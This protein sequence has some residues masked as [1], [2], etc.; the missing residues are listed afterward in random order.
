MLICSGN[1]RFLCTRKA[2]HLLELR[3]ILRSQQ[4][5]LRHVFF[6]KTLPTT[7][8]PSTS[9]LTACVRRITVHATYKLVQSAAKTCRADTDGRGSSLDKRL[10][11]LGCSNSDSDEADDGEKAQQSAHEGYESHLRARGCRPE[12]VG[13]RLQ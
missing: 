2:L 8:P 12:A 6:S 10:T 3:F 4:R 9:M 1:Y 7:M 5:V 13:V 11:T